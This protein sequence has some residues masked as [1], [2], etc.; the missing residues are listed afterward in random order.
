[1]PTCPA[2]RSMACCNVPGEKPVAFCPRRTARKAQQ[3]DEDQDPSPLHVACCNPRIF[4][5]SADNMDRAVQSFP[6]LGKI[7]HF[8]NGE[9]PSGTIV[10]LI[11]RFRNVPRRGRMR[12]VSFCTVGR[13]GFRLSEWA[14]ICSWGWLVALSAQITLEGSCQC[15]HKSIRD[16]S[17]QCQ[18]K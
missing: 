5:I 7:N 14:G 2:W 8:T 18:H 4:R 17:C 12:G 13:S 9:K 16:D 15:T 1:M 3:R 11:S 10:I 6:H